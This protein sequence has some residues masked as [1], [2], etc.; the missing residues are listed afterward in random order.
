MRLAPDIRGVAQAL[1]PTVPIPELQS[2]QE[3]MAQSISNR[4]VRALP[5]LGFGLLSLGVAFVGV[6]ATRSTLVAERRH[7]LAIRAALGA[8]P[9]RLTWPIVGQGVALTALG[10]VLGLGLGVAA[11]RGLS[12]LVYGLSPYDALTFAGTAVVIGGGAV[13]MT[14]AAALRARSVDPLVVLK[15]E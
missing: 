3:A 1:D 9:A 15:Y 12:S 10:L 13:L 4:R 14:Y 8:S 11:A 2:L 6:L 5:A 7:D